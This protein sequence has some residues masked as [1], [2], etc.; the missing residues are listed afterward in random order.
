M[1]INYKKNKPK[2]IHIQNYRVNSDGKTRKEIYVN[3]SH[4]LTIEKEFDNYINGE[5]KYIYKIYY[6]LVNGSSIVT[7]TLTEEQYKKL[8]NK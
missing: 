6:T 2:F 5:Y 8:Q 7:Q 3:I 4:I 1:T